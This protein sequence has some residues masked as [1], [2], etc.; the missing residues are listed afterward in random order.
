MRLLSIR[1]RADLE[2]EL[3]AV[4]ADP[5]SWPIFAAKSRVAAVKLD[6]LSTAGANIL[7]QTAIACGGDC[8]VNRA[9]VSG[10]VRRSDAVLLVTPRQLQA[11]ADRLTAQPECVARLV[12]ELVELSGRMLSPMRV[13]TLGRT[14]VDLGKRTHVMGILNVTPDSFSDGG[15]FLAPSAALE[16][17]VAMAEAGADFIDIGAE[18]TRPGARSVPAKE[19]LAR[20]MPVLR[21]V[22]KRVKV[23]VSIDT[24]SATVTEAVLREGAD[25]VN[26]VSALTGDPRM[27]AVVARFEVPCILMHMK[28]RPRT[29]QRDPK[30]SDL[31]SEITGFLEAALARGEQAGIKRTQMLVDPGIGFGKTVAHNLEI[32][33]R[34]AELESLGVPLVVGPSRK[35]F[36]GA[37][38]DASP[39]ERLEG[40]I[41]ACVL[42]AA[43]GANVLRVHDVKPVMKALRLAD[44]IGLKN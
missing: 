21:A 34:L 38:L 17:A 16:H 4:G 25:M 22:K 37:V 12:P 43:N 9:I 36:I 5:Q 24:T 41:A 19:Q 15:R 35:R 18:S 40:T 14:R 27:L 32:L 11:L 42:A 8:A 28:G 31:M 39:D 29:M 44:A 2:R 6:G 13:I 23:P 30:Y 7:K 20:L 33:R 10:R 3:A 1:N 26:D